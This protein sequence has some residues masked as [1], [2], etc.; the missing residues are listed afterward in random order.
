MR[1]KNILSACSL[2]EKLPELEMELSAEIDNFEKLTND[3]KLLREKERFH[4]LD[5]SDK[6]M[7]SL[8]KIPWESITL[9]I[10]KNWFDFLIF[11]DTLYVIIRDDNSSENLLN[12]VKLVDQKIFTFFFRALIH[13]KNMNIEIVDANVIAQNSES[14]VVSFKDF[15]LM[16]VTERIRNC[17]T[18]QD[19][20]DSSP[21]K[22]CPVCKDVTFTESTHFMFTMSCN[23]LVCLSCATLLV[24]FNHRLVENIYF[25][26]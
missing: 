13:F 7:I 17:E 11:I 21:T 10:F 16:R 23:H 4:I 14:S 22:E 9:P 3:D 8:N 6:I 12:V 25:L 26:F 5:L 15:F 2:F 1:N 18:I 24:E 19:L 20:I